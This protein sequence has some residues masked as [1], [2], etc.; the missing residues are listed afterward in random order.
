MLMHGRFKAAR[1]LLEAGVRIVTEPTTFIVP[2]NV[3]AMR[4]QMIAETAR[5]EDV[6]VLYFINGMVTGACLSR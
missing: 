1:V 3:L 4:L 2:P 6:R 5:K